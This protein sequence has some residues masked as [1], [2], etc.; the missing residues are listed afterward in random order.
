MSNKIEIRIDGRKLTPEKFLSGAS[1]FVALV[2]GVSKN[3]TGGKTE[4]VVEVDKGSAIV[5][6]RADNPPFFHAE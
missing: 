6:L 3:V 4:W 5:R 1:A 2:E